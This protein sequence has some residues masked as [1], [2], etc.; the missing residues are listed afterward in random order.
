[1]LPMAGDPVTTVLAIWGAVVSTVLA[2]LRIAEHLRDRPIIKVVLQPAMKAFP[3]F[4]IYGTMT[5]LI[6]KVVNV[7]KRPVSVTH[8]SLM[9]PGKGFLLCMDPH[10]AT[11]PVEL[12]ENKHHIFIFDEDDIRQ[13]YELRPTQYVACVS[14]AAGR[15]YWSHG[16]L[17]RLWK[18]GRIR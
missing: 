18:L 16:P 5:L 8:V 13:K 3:G 10:S 9:L 7:G 6:V 4:S 1:M 17:T 12:S 2:A 11:Y 15:N 14:D